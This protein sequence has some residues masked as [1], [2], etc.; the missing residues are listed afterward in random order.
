M[1]AR[2]AV[3]WLDEVKVRSH[4]R[5]L[6]DH[7]V[8]EKIYQGSVLEANSEWPVEVDDPSSLRLVEHPWRIHR[9]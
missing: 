7:I 9:V 6:R 2:K 4:R 1:D 3:P 8:L 5:M